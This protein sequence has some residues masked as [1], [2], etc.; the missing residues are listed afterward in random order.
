VDAFLAAIAARRG[1][2]EPSECHVARR[3]RWHPS[4][5][6]HARPHTALPDEPSSEKAPT[7]NEKAR[8]ECVVKFCNCR[9]TLSITKEKTPVNLTLDVETS[10]PTVPTRHLSSAYRLTRLN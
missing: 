10:K 6:S 2:E 9:S 7:E 8:A 4:G 3:T 5:D 1:E